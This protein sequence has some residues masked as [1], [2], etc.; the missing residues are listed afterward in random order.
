ML[1]S[2]Q[3]KEELLLTQVALSLTQTTGLQVVDMGQEILHSKTRWDA[4]VTLTDGTTQWKYLVEVKSLLTSNALEHLIYQ[5]TKYKNESHYPLLLVAPYI[6]PKQADKLRDQNIEFLDLAGNAYLKQPGLFVFITGQKPSE[7]GKATDQ[8]ARAFN[9]TGLRLIFALLTQPGLE[10]ET[11]R[12]QAQRSGISLGAVAWVMN[13]LQKL[14]YLEDRG[15]FGRRL[16]QKKELLDRWVP[17]YL[18]QL[19]PK[20]LFGRYQSSQPQWWEKVSLVIH[21][22][23]AFWGGEV[24]AEILTNYLQPATATVYAETNLPRLQAQFGLRKNQ[25]GNTE[26]LRKFWIAPEWE[27]KEK[28]VAPPLVVY[29]DLIALGDSRT[30]ETAKIIYD[31][32]LA[33]LVK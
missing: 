26:I 3:A 27:T 19:R 18:E 8:K 13:D 7:S 33:Q 31:Q 22:I 28:Q 24:G 17:A 12:V 4:E 20:L 9:Q 15:K 11:Y 25:L 1:R 23:G 2:Y 16:V 21:V 5:L 32:Y 14:G 29:A 10:Q 6:N 30:R